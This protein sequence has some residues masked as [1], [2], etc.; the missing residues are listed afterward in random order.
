MNIAE[1]REQGHGGK[2]LVGHDA[3][4][5]LCQGEA[6]ALDFGDC[7]L[8]AKFWLLYKLLYRSLHGAEHHGRLCKSDHFQY[9]NRLMELL[10][11][12]AQLAGVGRP[13]VRTACGFSLFC[14]SLERLGRGLQRFTELV[15][16]P[17]QRAQVTH[18]DIGFGGN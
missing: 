4:K 12:G 3:F 8:A 13:Q 15:E 14:K 1:L 11:C 16:H 10:A 17:G 6:G 5:I 18:D 9:P 7:V 2:R